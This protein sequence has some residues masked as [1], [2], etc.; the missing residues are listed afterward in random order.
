M[1]QAAISAEADWVAEAI[2]AHSDCCWARPVALELLED[3]G[4][5]EVQFLMHWMAGAYDGH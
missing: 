1:A 2:I 4:L 3:A 5:D